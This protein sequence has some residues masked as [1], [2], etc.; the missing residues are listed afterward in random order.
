MTR[1]QDR[2]SLCVSPYLIAG[3]CVDGPEEWRPVEGFAGY[4]VS[5]RGR[6]CSVDRIV[7][8][9]ICHGRILRAGTY[10]SGHRYVCL[11]RENHSQVHVLVLVA[12]VGPRPPKHEGLHADDNPANNM[13]TNL[14]WGTR[15]ENLHDAVRNGKKALGE[16]INHSKLTDDAV[17]VIR[18]NPAASLTSLGNRFGVSAQ[19]IKQVRKGTTWKHV[20]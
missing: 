18:A 16:K 11:G 20:A 13:L 17:R 14:R 1:R 6:V 9:K 5:D 12:F 19:A 7:S 4:F 2:S 8:G 15:S 10:P 3:P